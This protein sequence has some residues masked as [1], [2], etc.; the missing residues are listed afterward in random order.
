MVRKNLRT[1]DFLKLFVSV[2]VC[3]ILKQ[4]KA[5]NSTVH[6][7]RATKIYYNWIGFGTTIKCH[8]NRWAERTYFI[9]KNNEFNKI[10]KL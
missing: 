7:V 4:M 9:W 8:I 2:G 10:N 3:L 6:E 1:T 5:E